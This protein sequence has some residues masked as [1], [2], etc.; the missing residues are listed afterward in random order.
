MSV[1]PDAKILN[2]VELT[3]SSARHVAEWLDLKRQ[4]FGLE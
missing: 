2:F 1:T 4:R 3:R